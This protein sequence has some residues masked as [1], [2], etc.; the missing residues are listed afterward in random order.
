MA[1]IKSRNTN[2]ELI[3]RRCVHGLGYRFRLHGKDLPGKPDLVF[4]NRKSVIFVHGC[5][6]HQHDAARCGARPPKSNSQY[7]IPKLRKNIERDQRNLK[8][9]AKTGWRTLVIWECEIS[10]QDKLQKRV[11][12][13][14]DKKPRKSS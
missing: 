2:P 3:V 9:L 7:W 10:N 12:K 4:R 14:L 11:T 1:A 5:F 6:W 13:F 8:V